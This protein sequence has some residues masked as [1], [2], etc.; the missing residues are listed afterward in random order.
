MKDRAA[1]LTSV[2]AGQVALKGNKHLNWLCRGK[3]KGTQKRSAKAQACT[4]STERHVQRGTQG[5]FWALS[6][7]CRSLIYLRRL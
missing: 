5:Q 4:E 6:R 3:Q 2:A 7:L 1:Y